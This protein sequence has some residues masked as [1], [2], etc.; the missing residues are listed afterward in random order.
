MLLNLEI[1]QLQQV[2][3]DWVSLEAQATIFLSIIRVED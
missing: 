2:R 1:L 3:F